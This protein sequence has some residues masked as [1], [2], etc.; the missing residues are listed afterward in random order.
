MAAAGKIMKRGV[1]NVVCYIYIL[2]I[3]DADRLLLLLLWLL[4]KKQSLQHNKGNQQQQPTRIQID[5]A[6]T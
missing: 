4:G 3:Y 1:C 2:H 5:A 6:R